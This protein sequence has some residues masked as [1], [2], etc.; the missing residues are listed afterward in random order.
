MNR[1]VIFN[2][3]YN[4]QMGGAKDF[5]GSYPTKV[6][7]KTI[8]KK[9][10]KENFFISWIQIF[11]KITDEYTSYSVVGGELKERNCS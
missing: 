11:D 1:F 6:E 2:G 4:L 7:A 8:A 9:I 3:N 10:A 5:K